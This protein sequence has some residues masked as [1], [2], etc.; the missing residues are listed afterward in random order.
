MFS[1]ISIQESWLF[2]G[3]DTSLIQLEGYKCIP[4]VIICISK[5]GLMI[6]LHENF[7]Y[8]LELN[9]Y[10]TWEGQC[11]EIM[12]GKTLNKPLYIGNIYRPP[13]KNL[14]FYNQFIEEFAP[15][16]VNLD[17]NNKDV[18]LAGDFNIDL[19]KINE[20]H[21]INEY[22]DMLT[23]NSVYPKITVPT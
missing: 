21:I 19:L 14:E 12:R 23:I 9:D 10:T 5:G 3:S 1:A 8:K 11:I 13:P 20:K 18:I 16:L 4:Q 6:Y 15:I 7:K 2:E 17:K 22:F